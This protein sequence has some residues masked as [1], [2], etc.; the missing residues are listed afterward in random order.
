M[1]SEKLKME[2]ELKCP[3]SAS[4]QISM[5]RKSSI[6]INGLLVYKSLIK[7]YSIYY[8]TSQQQGLHWKHFHWPEDDWYQQDGQGNLRE[9]FKMGKPTLD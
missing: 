4:V 6:L 7:E 8:E 5:I 9:M 3:P 1:E 2:Q